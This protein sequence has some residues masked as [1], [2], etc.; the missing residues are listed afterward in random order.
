MESL[1]FIPYPLVSLIESYV[2]SHLLDGARIRGLSL[3]FA[4]FHEAHDSRDF[5]AVVPCE[6]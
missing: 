6:D 2:L 4:L 1:V 5:D 3:H